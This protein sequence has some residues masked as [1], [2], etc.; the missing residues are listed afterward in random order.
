MAEAKTYHLEGSTVVLDPA[1]PSGTDRA[2]YLVDVDGIERGIVKQWY[3]GDWEASTLPWADAVWAYELRRTER[4]PADYAANPCERLAR[5]FVEWTRLGLAPSQDDWEQM[6]LSR[7]A[8]RDDAA[9]M[10]REMLE[11]LRS[12]QERLSGHLTELEANAVRRA[13]DKLQGNK[14]RE[15]R[16][17]IGAWLK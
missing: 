13:I 7:K 15:S 10:N 5:K 11:G 2:L 6:R 16:P 9:R 17:K 4:I 14:A 8:A 1:K 12:I 3:H